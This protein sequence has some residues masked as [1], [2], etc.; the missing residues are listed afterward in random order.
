MRAITKESPRTRANRARANTPA[1]LKGLLWGSD[2]GAFSPTH[3]CKNGK[4]YRYYVSQTLLRHGAGSTAVGRVP[5]AEIEGAVVNQ[6]RA[7]F[8]QPEIIIGAWKEAVKHAPAMTEA[9]AR[10]ALINVDPMWD[11]LF[12]AE[13]ARI[14][15][16]LV[17]RVIVGSAGLELKLRVDGLDALARELQVP[18][19]EE[20]A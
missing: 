12:P 13:Q 3:S 5:A 8:R 9:Q 11:E 20:A 2:G 18:E 16:L 17:D 6:L 7:V 14:V 1:L 19:L 15:Q 4:L 10:E